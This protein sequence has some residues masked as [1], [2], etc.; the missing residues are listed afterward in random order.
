MSLIL[1]IYAIGKE[2]DPAFYKRALQDFSDNGQRKLKVA[3][4]SMFML[5]GAVSAERTIEPTIAEN[6]SSV[7]GYGGFLSASGLQ[8]ANSV[9]ESVLAESERESDVWMQAAE[10]YFSVVVY[11]KAKH[12]LK[13][14]NDQFGVCPTF[15]Y[16]TDEYFMF[17]N[18]FQ[19]LL[20]LAEVTLNHEAV[21]CY[22]SLGTTLP[23]QTFC[24]EITNLNPG[25]LIQV[26]AGAITTHSLHKPNIPID[27]DR[28]NEEHAR[29]LAEA[30]SE[31]VNEMASLHD[32][33]VC[34][35]SGGADTRLV[36]SCLSEDLRSSLKFLTSFLPVHKKEQDRDVIAAVQIAQ[37]LNL[38][39]RVSSV[40]FNNMEFDQSYFDRERQLRPHPVLGGWLGGEFLGGLSGSI[41]PIKRG[42]TREQ[43]DAHLNMVFS[44][45]FINALDQHPFD[46]YQRELG[47][48]G[49]ENNQLEFEINL[50]TRAFF[51]TLWGGSKGYWLQPYQNITKAYTPFCDSR[52]IKAL[53]KVPFKL[54]DNYG[55]Y[56][57]IYMNE[58]PVLK[59]IPSNSPLTSRDDSCIPKSDLGTE[60]ELNIKPVHHN[61]LRNRSEDSRIWDRGMYRSAVRAT[62]ENDIN[63]RLSCNFTDFEA[64]AERYSI[65]IPTVESSWPGWLTRLFH[66]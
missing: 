9:V 18:E 28:T 3:S 41:G 20:T 13:L 64:L 48:K 24:K 39:H 60:P 43:V 65:P 21:A 47:S 51:S 7:V 53:L 62:I 1:G 32:D 54:I 31:I 11:N 59:D 46:L 14:F 44:K 15:T 6:E 61:Y 30:I 22:F 8:N 55:L 58:R 12:E 10:G 25:N 26:R 40:S 66:K 16:Q 57:L 29:D 37:K 34:L 45:G 2:L 27:E 4:S 49:A 38:D 36:V 19:P 33:T 35:L 52:F 42:I 23:G 63:S 56:N 17:C 50:I 5:A